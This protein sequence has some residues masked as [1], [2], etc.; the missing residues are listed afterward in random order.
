MVKKLLSLIVVALYM[1]NNTAAMTAEEKVQ[2]QEFDKG[3]DFDECLD[4]C[5]EHHRE[6]LGWRRGH[7]RGSCW[8][9]CDKAHPKT[10]RD[11]KEARQSKKTVAN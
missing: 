4:N 10:K 1:A 3:A 8:R 7:G 2:A 6:K 5:H 9:T 11:A